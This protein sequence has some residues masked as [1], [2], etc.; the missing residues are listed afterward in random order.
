MSQNPLELARAK[1]AEM[2]SQ[3]IKPSFTVTFSGEEAAVLQAGAAKTDVIDGSSAREYVKKV[4]MIQATL[5]AAKPTK[6]RTTKTVEQLEAEAAAL[7]A[8]IAKAKGV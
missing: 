3:G 7:A 5:D 4:A 8:R 6:P 2:K 1:R